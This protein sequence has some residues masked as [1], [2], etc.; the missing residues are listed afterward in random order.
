MKELAISYSDIKAIR[1]AFDDV[2]Y[3]FDENARIRLKECGFMMSDMYAL[4]CEL[5]YG[6]VKR[7]IRIVITR[8]Y[9]YAFENDKMI[10]RCELENSNIYDVAVELIISIIIK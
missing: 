5:C 6:S 4:D 3:S 10:A 7:T 9:I 1:N 8:Y 2:A